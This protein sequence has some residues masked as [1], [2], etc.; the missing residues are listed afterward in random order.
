MIKQQDITSLDDFIRSEYFAAWDESNRDSLGYSRSPFKRDRC[1]RIYDG[2]EHGAEGSTH[3]EIIADW[4][5][6]FGDFQRDYELPEK[7]INTIEKEINDC[8]AWH[9]KNGSLETQLG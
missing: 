5:E 1:E 8:E 9:E 3:G 6:S 7:I 2:A 4:R